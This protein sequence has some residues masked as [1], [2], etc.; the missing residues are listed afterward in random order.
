MNL[1]FAEDDVLIRESY[2]SFLEI[3]FDNI[4]EANDGLEALEIYKN[5]E[6]DVILSDI[7]MPNLDGLT[8]AKRVREKDKDT[9]IIMLTAY[10]D[11]TYLLDAVKLYLLDYLVKPVNRI[12]FTQSI[13]K[14][15]DI[16][17]NQNKTVDT[18][19][20]TGGYIWNKKEKKLYLDNEE[21]E[22][23]QKEQIL[24]LTFCTAAN[25]IFT[26]EDIFE[27]LYKEDTYSD[28]KVRM[29]LKRLKQKLHTEIIKNNYGVGYNFILKK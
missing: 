5:K 23:T 26:N 8:F 24:F 18:V 15:V 25:Q 12:K 17:K 4:Y 19:K 11:K 10:D 9:I 7:N 3:Y 14:A 21:I 20:L 28:N 1:L 27:L 13:K 22:L 2:R 16:K 29:I 6:I